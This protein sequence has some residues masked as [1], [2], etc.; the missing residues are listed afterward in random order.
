MPEKNLEDKLTVNVTTPVSD[1]IECPHCVGMVTCSKTSETLKQGDIIPAWCPFIGVPA[2][3]EPSD[4]ERA[5]YIAIKHYLFEGCDC[6]I[7]KAW[8]V[9][10]ED[11]E[12]DGCDITPCV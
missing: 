8:Q 12:Y 2:P 11:C 9:V 5:M 7:K 1:C 4:N 3:D 10:N 6:M